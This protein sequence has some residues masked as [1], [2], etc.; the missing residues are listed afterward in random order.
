M[1]FSRWTNSVTREAV[2]AAKI[3]YEEKFEIWLSAAQSALATAAGAANS[4]QIFIIP[5]AT[6]NLPTNAAPSALTHTRYRG[7]HS[8][9]G[10]GLCCWFLDVGELSATHSKS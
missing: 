5:V 10:A 1:K 8:S 2:Q 6:P 7:H 9:Y 3:P 4:Q